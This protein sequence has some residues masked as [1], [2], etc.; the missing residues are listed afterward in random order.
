[1]AT[2][3]ISNTI[4]DPNGVAVASVPVTVRLMPAGGFRI[5]TFTEVARVVTTTT[6]GSGTWSLALERNSNITPDNSWY[7]IVEDVPGT[8]GGKRVW[9]IQVGAS[10]QTVLA[11][12]VTPAERFATDNYLT[13]TSA[14][15]RYQALGG[16]SSA[17]PNTIEPDDAASAGVSTSAS[18]A[19]HEH[20]IVAAAASSIGTANSEGAAT[21]FAR[22]DHV[23]TGAALG[24]LSSG[25]APA[26][27]NQ[28][29]ITT[30]PV[31]LTSL[32][33]TVTTVAG[34]RY[35]ITAQCA[36][37]ET[38]ATVSIVN[39]TILQDGVQVGNI[40]LGDPAAQAETSHGFAII[41]PAA[42]SHTFKLQGSTNA[43]TVSLVATATE[44]AF[45]L[46]EDIG[47]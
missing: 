30:T 33:V 24:T 36:Y 41:T 45:I 14:D 9:N 3:T 26:T 13:Q 39:T 38:V 43:G 22:S 25:Y 37:A 27:A 40:R 7:E 10:D 4:T 5:D 20:G 46:I 18:R 12:L 1:M 21:S 44:P 19:D 35:K 31:D 28:T 23:H 32:T 8:A 6:N 34:R 16:L 17:T 29:G 47:T 42:G 2:S 11:S 15:A